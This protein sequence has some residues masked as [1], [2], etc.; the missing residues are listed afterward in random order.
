V[1]ALYA[2]NPLI[3][4][5]MELE[6]DLANLK[7]GEK[8]YNDNRYRL[9][10]QAEIKFPNDISMLKANIERFSVDKEVADKNA[11]N[12]IIS[13]N[14]VEYDKYGTASV[15]I[16][17]ECFKLHEIGDSRQIGMYMSF[18]MYIQKND[19]HPLETPPFSVILKGS[20]DYITNIHITT[21]EEAKSGGVIRSVYALV[22]SID[23]NLEKTK[24]A[25]KS[26]TAEWEQ[27]I[28][29]AA[30]PFKERDELNRVSDRLEEVNKLL[31][32]SDNEMKLPIELYTQDYNIVPSGLDC[33]WLDN[34]NNKVAFTT[35]DGFGVTID[36][37]MDGNIEISDLEGTCVWST[38]RR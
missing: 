20:R 8:S 5:K 17:A 25:L 11:E 18:K 9:Q 3:K 16:T 33:T 27:V 15:A 10:H 21:A 19:I 7:T 35:S 36:K 29:Q 28:V 13:V 4:E 12:D 38:W 34:P 26:K 1:K 37:N 32:E 30:E 14:G 31:I 6:S 23:R 2:G 22:K 24:A